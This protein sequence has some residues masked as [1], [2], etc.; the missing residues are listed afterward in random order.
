MNASK[1]VK[2]LSVAGVAA[3]ALTFGIGQ[4]YAA[5]VEL[6]TNGGFETGT[7]AGWIPV[8]NGSTGGC[9]SN[10]WEVNTT[11]HQGCQSN[12]TT[13]S[14]PISGIYGAFNTFDGAATPYTLTQQI[15]VPDSVLG[16]TL[17]FLDEFHMSY[18]GTLRTFRVDFYDA[19][20]STLL[21]NVFSQ[22][23]GYNANQA[24]TLN[25]FDV[26]SLLS[27]QAGKTIDLRFTE[28]IPQGF[29]GP[30]GF[31]LDNV[32]LAATVPEPATVALLG[33]GLLGFAA[34]RRKSA[35]SKNA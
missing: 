10:V 25:T 12:G 31:G 7:F 11:G 34:S 22:N 16:A 19:I 1:L 20:G 9:G 18:S 21:D 15:A 28:I 33:L 3:A 5:P 2:K 30:A 14:A 23:P 6:I 35:H 29:T 4:A 8:S 24:W 26:T 17:S 32:S 13:V 27:A